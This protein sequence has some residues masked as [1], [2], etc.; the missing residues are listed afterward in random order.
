M[1]LSQEEVAHLIN[2]A[3]TPFH[4]IV[5]MT[6]YATGV[7][8]AELARLKISDIDSQRMVIHVRVA[9]DARIVMSCS[10]LCCWTLCVDTGVA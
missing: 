10:A 6:L 8:R 7:R 4:R 3:R 5:L 9:K 2:S 1:I